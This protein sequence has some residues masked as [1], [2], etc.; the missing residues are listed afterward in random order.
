[1]YRKLGNKFIFL[2]IVPI[3]IISIIARS[4][5]LC[6]VSFPRND[7][8]FSPSEHPKGLL[9]LSNTMEVVYDYCYYCGF[10]S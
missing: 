6:M 5:Y 2:Y 10:V 4:I 1:M 8:K 3:S 9:Q 7:S